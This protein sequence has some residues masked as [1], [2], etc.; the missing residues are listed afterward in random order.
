MARKKKST[1]VETSFYRVAYR[2]MGIGFEFSVV[3]GGCAFIGH[4]LDLYVGPSPGWMIM[5]FFV[6][7]GIMMYI[8]VKRAQTTEKELEEEERRDQE[9]QA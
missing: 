7:F 9:D 2:W 5:G 1:Q 3:I 6:G 8:I 4:L